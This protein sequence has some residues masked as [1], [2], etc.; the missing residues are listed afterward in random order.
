MASVI[1]EVKPCSNDTPLLKLAHALNRNT[2][3]VVSSALHAQWHADI[4]KFMHL[5]LFL[6][7]RIHRVTANCAKCWIWSFQSAPTFTTHSRL[8]WNVDVKIFRSQI[9]CFRFINLMLMLW[10]ESCHS[11]DPLKTDKGN[12]LPDFFHGLTHHGCSIRVGS[13]LF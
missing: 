6:N 10:S 13:G 5:Y 3:K 8:L 11:F 9:V 4:L 12:P 2:E 1:W 7:L